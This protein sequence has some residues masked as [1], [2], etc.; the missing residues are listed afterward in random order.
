VPFRHGGFRHAKTVMLPIPQLMGA[1]TI[2]DLDI[3][4]WPVRL[5]YDDWKGM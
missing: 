5:F 3:D 4:L 1:G 2:F